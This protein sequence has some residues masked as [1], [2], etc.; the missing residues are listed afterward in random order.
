MQE[1]EYQKLTMVCQHAGRST[2]KLLV[3][4][5]NTRVNSGLTKKKLV[6]LFK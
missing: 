2:K 5:F 6:D 3:E 4:L 1:G